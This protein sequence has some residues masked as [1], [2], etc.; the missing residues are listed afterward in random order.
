[1][2]VYTTASWLA[3]IVVEHWGCATLKVHYVGSLLAETA[4]IFHNILTEF[5]T[6]FSLEY[7]FL[8]VTI[9]HISLIVSFE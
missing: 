5:I 7:F 2:H 3:N 4:Y 6:M 9:N 1:M 8:P